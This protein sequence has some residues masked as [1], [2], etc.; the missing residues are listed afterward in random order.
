MTGPRRRMR[1]LTALAVTL[2]LLLVPSARPALANPSALC[3]EAALAASRA[4][5][6]PVTVLRAISL[7]E[8]GRRRAGVTRPWPWT[9]DM[10]GKGV[11]FTGLDEALAYVETSYKSGARSFD[12]GCFQ[13]NHR[14]H[15]NAFGSFREMFEPQANALYAARFL[16]DLFDE[17]GDWT[18]AA[19]AYHSRTPEHA[20]RYAAI[21]RKHHAAL[22][23]G[24]AAPPNPPEPAPATA[25]TA[26]TATVARVNHYPLLLAGTSAGLGSI[27]PLREAGQT[28]LAS[29]SLLR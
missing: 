29:A 12:L 14:W 1:R 22:Q 4:T 6:V 18:K 28:L 3:D 26:V 17:L 16:K 2:G 21:F 24:A 19:G 8:T 23:N 15:G 10:E 7:T 13:L 25:A 11:W 5:G 9:V 27:V 20:E